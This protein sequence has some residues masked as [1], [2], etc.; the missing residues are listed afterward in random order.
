[1]NYPVDAFVMLAVP[2][3]VARILATTSEVKRAILGKL[4]SMD[5]SG[6]SLE[7]PVGRPAKCEG[8]VNGEGMSEGL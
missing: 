7:S 5:V 3:T 4:P 6:N 1:M 8:I 2:A